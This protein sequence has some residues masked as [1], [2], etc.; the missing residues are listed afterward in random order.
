MHSS[1]ALRRGFHCST[2]LLSILRVLLVTGGLLGLF[3]V[4]R[5][6]LADEAKGPDSAA[7]LE[8]VVKSSY[9][10]NPPTNGA[11]VSRVSRPM[12][13]SL[14]GG[15]TQSFAYV[16]ATQ[17]GFVADTFGFGAHARGADGS[18]QYVVDGIP[19]QAAPL[20]QWNAASGFLPLRL[21]QTLSIMTGG[22]PAEYGSGLGA[23]VDIT[24]RHATGPAAGVVQATYGTYH[25]ADL[26]ANYSQEFERLSVLGGGNVMTTD[27]GLDPPAASPILHDKLVSGNAFA[28]ADYLVSE[29]ERLQLITIFNQSRF[30]IPIDP[31]LRPLSEAPRGAIRG[32]DSYGNPPPP[33]VPYDA[34]PVDTERNLF[35]A[36]SY[37]DQLDARS[38]VQVASYVR[39]SLG[40]LT[41]D[42]TATLGPLA[43][44]GSN[45][46]DV[47]REVVHEGSLISYAWSR[48][49]S[50]HWKTGMLVD[51]AQSR[52][53]YTAYYR[54]DALVTGGPDP[55]QTLSGR[56]VTH[57]MLLGAYLQDK[58]DL[59][60]FSI[61]P[62]VRVDLQRTAFLDS[63]EPQQ[64]LL[65]PSARL[66]L[67][68]QPVGDL[69]FHAFG[70]YLWQPPSTID[71][72]VAA[73]ILVPALAQQ[74][75]PVNIRAE[76]DWSAEVG[77]AD[78]LLKR[79]TLTLTSWGRI[80]SDPLDR[81]N[82]GTT[83]LVAS[84][85]FKRGRAVG[86]EAGTVASVCNE[87]DGFANLG[88]QIAQAQGINSE[89]FLFTA[90]QLASTS[91]ETLDHAQTWTAN[92]GFD[93]HDIDRASHFS[94]LINYG[95]GLRTGPDSNRTVPSHATVDVT[96]RHRFRMVMHPEVA[97]N[98]FNLF[99]DV[100]ALRIASGYV[101]SAYGSL[102]RVDIRVSVPFA[103]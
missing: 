101:G 3:V 16:L 57:V 19:L 8:V 15:D 91:W 25:H 58:I 83:N 92:V 1:D 61:F 95:S 50:Q 30:Q 2:D 54:N 14:P 72:P 103:P 67:S 81:V 80:A 4:T 36:V 82:V 100:Y 85:N 7:D 87:L 96:L 24:T 68:Y 40:A 43:D 78:R 64:V 98:V 45:C 13:D 11:S 89:R 46:S 44:S 53:D 86:V 71:A 63:D 10:P 23:A 70:G 93:L 39:E 28:R 94:G 9:A 62:G 73:R 79:L 52:V 97:V 21:V 48:G 51:H 17:P 69:V 32:P 59:G 55:A 88:W 60:R 22:F 56:D 29:H 27:R 33:F 6:A 34:N 20:G 47:R 49:T 75:L 65:G 38:S 102:R 77:I 41:C 12:I 66:G 18:L 26:S 5:P 90:D 31:T 76:K 99:N 74:R 84:Y 42:A 37:R 35:A